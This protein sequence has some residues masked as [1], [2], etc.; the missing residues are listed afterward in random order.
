MSLDPLHNW[1][2][3][4]LWPVGLCFSIYLRQNDVIL[5]STLGTLGNS[6]FG[7]LGTFETSRTLGNSNLDTS[8]TWGDSSFGNSGVLSTLGILGFGSSGILGNSGFGIFGNSGFGSSTFGE[9]GIFGNSGLGSSGFPGTNSSKS[10]RA[11][12]GIV[13]QLIN[14]KARSSAKEREEMASHG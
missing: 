3:N 4:R 14:D 1:V 9:D 8:G 13:L 7:T 10:H 11:A 5:Q 2:C 6:G 12:T